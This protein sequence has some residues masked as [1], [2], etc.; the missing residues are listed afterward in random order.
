MKIFILFALASAQWE[1]PTYESVLNS[2]KARLAWDWYVKTT[3]WTKIEILDK[4]EILDKNQNFGQ[5]P[6]F[7]TKTQFSTKI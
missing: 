3:F 7:W 1:Q 4:R 5:K 6:K 2:I